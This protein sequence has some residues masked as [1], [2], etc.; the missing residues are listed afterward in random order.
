MP[1]ELPDDSGELETPPSFFPYSSDQEREESEVDYGE[2]VEV[3]V[4]AVYANQNGANV[5]HYVLL[6]D[7]DRKLPIMIGGFEAASITYALD[8][9]PP[10]RPLTH[11]LIKTILDKVGCQVTQVLIDDFWNGI[12]YAKIRV[13]FE[14]ETAEIDC[15]PSDAIAIA[16]RFESPVF[17]ANKIIELNQDS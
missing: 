7:G 8:E 14:G 2:P 9:Q 16:I 15:R 6:T 3:E 11:D 12:Y 17:V 1:E 10:D 5:Q 4:Q 13:E